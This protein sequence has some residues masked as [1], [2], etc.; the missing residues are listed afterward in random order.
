MSGLRY[1]LRGRS[2]F[3]SCSLR[4]FF[5]LSFLFIFSANLLLSQTS[6]KG[7]TSTAWGT[8]SNWTNGVPT[9]TVDTIIGDANFTG[10]SQPS[11]TVAST[12]K[13]LILGS[14]T[15]SSTLTMGSSGRNLTGND[16][17]MLSVSAIF[18]GGTSL[19][20]TFL[21]SWIVNTMSATSFS[22]NTASTLHFNTV[23]L[24]NGGGIVPSSG[25]IVN[26]TFSITRNVTFTVGASTGTSIVRYIYK[27]LLG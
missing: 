10:S 2:V 19:T 6:W 17:L 14:G 9:P 1:C 26:G 7:I 25:W 3:C 24:N 16:N 22:F 12:C 13:S 8:A 21:G 11:I 4:S 18:A 5:F 27:N 23:N 20:H 15:K